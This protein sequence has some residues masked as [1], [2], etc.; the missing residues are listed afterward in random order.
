[1]LRNQYDSF[2]T[3]GEIKMNTTYLVSQHRRPLVDVI[4]NQPSNALG[5][6][7]AKFVSTVAEL[8]INELLLVLLDLLISLFLGSPCVFSEDLVEAA[9]L[10]FLCLFN[11][12]E[13]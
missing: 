6:I 13:F 7:I 4:A 2:A 3:D 5:L 10:L 12:I 8:F 9:F 1:M 11:C